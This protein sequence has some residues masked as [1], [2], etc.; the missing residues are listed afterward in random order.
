M[1]RRDKL[2]TGI[3]AFTV[4]LMGGTETRELVAE[5]ITQ[6]RLSESSGIGRFHEREV[7]TYDRLED[8]NVFAD[9]IRNADEEPGAVNTITP[10][11]EVEIQYKSGEIE[12]YYV[13]IGKPGTSTSLIN[14]N[15]S[16]TV[17]RVAGDITERLI[18]LLDFK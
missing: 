12:R 13:W 16:N 17:Y 4:G 5:D 18:Q 7:V 6:V 14:L 9:M 1:K 10:E 3:A 15:D 11:Y 8:V 2:M